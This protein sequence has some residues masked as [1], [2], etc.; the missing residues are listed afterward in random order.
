MRRL[1]AAA[2][3]A[4]WLAAGP[5]AWAQEGVRTARIE[6]S[7]AGIRAATLSRESLA[8]LAAVE[9]DVVFQT[10]KGESKGRYRGVLLWAVLEKAGLGK[11]G[12][13]HPALRQTF[14]VTGRDGYAIAFSVGEVAPDFGDTPVMIATDR[15]GKP[16]P[17]EEGLR[18]IVPGDK[19]GARNVRDVATIELR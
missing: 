17:P 16:L 3:L 2:V 5:A 1:L 19:R 11:G 18:L 15:D 6:L 8:G 12:D 13:I 9:K 7:G 4:P 10:S 14:V